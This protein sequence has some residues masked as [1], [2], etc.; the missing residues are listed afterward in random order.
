[1]K[2]RTKYKSIA[3]EILSADGQFVIGGFFDEVKDN[4]PIF[5]DNV[6]DNNLS[7]YLKNNNTNIVELIAKS[8]IYKENSFVSKEYGA[9]QQIDT[10][11]TDLNPDYNKLKKVLL[12]GEIIYILKNTAT[13][14][15]GDIEIYCEFYKDVEQKTTE[16]IKKEIDEKITSNI[17]NI[18][19]I[20]KKN[21]TNENADG[22]RTEFTFN[23]TPGSA[24]DKNPSYIEVNGQI[25]AETQNAVFYDLTEGVEKGTFNNAG[26]TAAFEFAD[27]PVNGASIIL[28]IN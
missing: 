12:T 24:S 25:V 4:A 6:Q 10:G 14:S 8:D 7:I 2:S 17:S 3:S 26:G 13:F 16:E 22:T 11:R 18:P 9:D 1:M 5:E 27:P 23:F 21:S 20:P 28:K 15:P 19:S